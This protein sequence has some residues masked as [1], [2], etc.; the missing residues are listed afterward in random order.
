MS[1]LRGIALTIASLPTLILQG[2]GSDSAAPTPSD[3]SGLYEV[4]TDPSPSTC[5]PASAAEDLGR[6]A[7]ALRMT[8]RVEQLDAQVRMTVVSTEG[9]DGRPV[10]LDSQ[11]SLGPLAADGTF[12]FENNLHG[13][14]VLDDRTLFD[15]T[16]VSASGHFERD[17]DPIT[18]SLVSSIT[19]VVHEGSAT[20]P[21]FA[22]CVETQTATAVRIGD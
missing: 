13:S 17:A 20:G 9:T 5:T 8:L 14:F 4:V 16:T 1:G 15:E 19:D 6:G 10:T 3:V 12:Q 11:P 7:I 22:T 21:V 18:F 2:C